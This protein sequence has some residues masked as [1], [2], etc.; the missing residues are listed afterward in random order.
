M[1]PDSSSKGPPGSHTQYKHSK[2]NMPTTSPPH[3][4]STN[5]PTSTTPQPKSDPDSNPRSDKKVTK[6]N[7]TQ[8][9]DQLTKIHIFKINL[10]NFTPQ[11]INTVK[12][13]L[14]DQHMTLGPHINITKA[15]YNSRKK[16]YQITTTRTQ[17]EPILWIANNAID[18]NIFTIS[19]DAIHTTNKPVY[20]IHLDISLSKHYTNQT[21]YKVLTEPLNHHSILPI[22]K[23]IRIIAPPK[24]HGRSTPIF[25]FLIET[26]DCFKAFLKA[27][28]PPNTT[29]HL[30][31]SKIKWKPM[32]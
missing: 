3:T 10:T 16:A 24:D 23:H 22:T 8:P 1:R 31:K 14:T 12:H 4:V 15:T 28:S 26:T 13:N 7:S 5:P 29:K 20:K 9:Q 17:L 21:L 30:K 25:T 32:N 2:G 19:T 6:L 27:Q 11:E 18:K